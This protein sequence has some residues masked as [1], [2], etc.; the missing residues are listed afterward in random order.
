MVDPTSDLN[1]DV[2]E[3]NAPRCAACGDPVVSAHHR[4]V[5]WVEGDA[6]RTEHFCDA[7]CRDEWDGP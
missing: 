4:V 2:D 3:D 7:S 1:E 6:A 5:T